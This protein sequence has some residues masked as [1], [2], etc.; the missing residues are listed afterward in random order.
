MQID[1]RAFAAG[2]GAL[3][4]AGVSANRARAAADAWTVFVGT[5]TVPKGKAAGIVGL[6][7]DK[8]TG[9]MTQVSETVARNPSFLA[10]NSARTRL[11]ASN[12]VRDFEGQPSGYVTAYEVL[13]NG[14]LRELGKQPS[15][16]V[17]PAHCALD[18]GG[19]FLIASNFISGHFSVLPLDAEGRIL[20]STD[21][22][23]R[24]GHGPHIGR[25]LGPHGH[26]VAINPVTG[27]VACIDLGADGV[28]VYAIGADGKWVSR[29]QRMIVTPGAGPRH[30]VYSKD[31][32]YLYVLNEIHNSVSIFRTRK[33]G[34][35]QP[36][37]TVPTLPADLRANASASELAF[38]AD[39]R[40]LV[41]AN[42]GPNT[43]AVF[44]ADPKSGL[45]GTPRFFPVDG[46]GPR[47]FG[48]TPDD[49]MIVAC[50]YEGD[51][52]VSYRFDKAT[53]KISTLFRKY[54]P[55]PACAVFI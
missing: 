5:Y 44:E 22:V 3:A 36:I 25:Q 50:N 34:D 17:S 21:R 30:A 35:V 2:L 54:I 20:P 12:E 32:A 45:L 29:K 28:D 51:S 16:G 7:L 55:T 1:R 10:L 19:R 33:A 15:N 14:G 6:S 52:V 27:D 48:F 41:T 9:E 37:A 42:R 53:G 31:G 49:E 24:S 47:H 43:F 4:A 40:F 18:G 38:D 11:Y 13:P 23:A 46:E 8:A 26:G 39:G